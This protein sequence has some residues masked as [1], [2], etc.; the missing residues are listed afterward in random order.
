MEV[1]VLIFAEDGLSRQLIPMLQDD[2]IKVVGRLYDEN[3]ILDM[4]TKAKPDIVLLSSQNKTLLL[5]VCQQIYLLRPR[6]IPV[7]ITEEYTPDFIHKVIQTGVHYVL[8]MQIDSNTLVTQLKGIQGNESTRMTALENTGNTNWKSKVV[9]VFST[10]GGL[11]KTSLVTN[12]AIKLA[13]KKRKVAILDFDLEFGD[14]AGFLRID[15]KSTIS[16]LLEE[17]SSLNADNIRK[18]MAVHASGVNVLQAPLSPEYA[19]NISSQSVDKI[20]SSLRTYYDYLIIDTPVGFNSVN[21]AAFD[22][23]SEVIFVTGMDLASL[24]GSKKGLNIVNSL[25]GPEKVRLVVAKEEPS[26][27]KLSDVSRA[28]ETQVWHSI[29]YDQKIALEAVNLGKPIVMDSPMSK[30]AKNYQDLANKLDGSKNGEKQNVKGQKTETSGF[31]GSFMGKLK[32]KK[33]DK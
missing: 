10:K 22:A 9:T 11:G 5:R 14:V 28:L 29:S 31:L 25:I 7:V 30:V 6:S 2:N 8:P 12:L 17:Q 32:G 13:Q 33:G 23:S 27:V 24:K 18:Y 1:K 4:I 20:I 26:R 21:L 16:S 15:S 19:G 3:S